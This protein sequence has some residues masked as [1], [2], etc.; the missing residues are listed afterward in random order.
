MSLA[1]MFDMGDDK[2]LVGVNLV[3]FSQLV[4]STVMATFKPGEEITVDTMRHLCLNTIRANVSKNKQR[5]PT[6]VIC[7]DNAK[8]GYWRRDVASYYKKNRSKSREE[9]EWDWTTI[10]E[11]MATVVQELKDHMPYK[12]IDKTKT[13]ADDAIAVLCKH[14]YQNHPGCQILITSS[15]G[16]FTQLHKFKTVKQWSPIQKKWVSCKHGSPRNDLRFKIIKGDKKDAIA[17][18]NCRSDYVI[19]KEE[20]ERAPAISTKKTLEPLLKADNPLE[21]GILSEE[22]TKR[23]LENE[24]LLDFEKIPDYIRDPI[25]DEFDSGAVAPRRKMYPYFVSRRLVKLTESMS[26]F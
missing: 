8:D 3:D 13:E 24:V 14:I 19:T 10:F 22:Q 5:Y 15:D 12:V 6:V 17:G 26:D 21:I 9:S 4:I 11:G 25:I 7:V 18:V 20:G 16:D 23:Y 1:S 2:S